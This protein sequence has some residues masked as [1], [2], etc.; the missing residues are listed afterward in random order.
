MILS[1]H[2]FFF[3]P[4]MT[5]VSSNILSILVMAE[6]VVGNFANVFIALVN[7][8]DWAKNQKISTADAILTALAVSRIGLLWVILLNWCSTVFNPAL[9]PSEMRIIV[10]NTWTV[11]NHFSLWLTA[12]LSIFYLLKIANFSNLTFLYLKK[13]IKSVV[14]ETMLVNFVFLVCYLVVLNI[15]QSIQR[16][17][18][19]GNATWKIK[20][21][22]IVQLS[23]MTVLTLVNLIPFTVSLICFLLLT[24]SLCKHLRNMQLHGLGSRDPSTQVHVKA[25][26][27]V[28]SFLLL[29]AMYFLA[30][31]ISFWSSGK[32]MSKLSH[33]FC[34]AIGIIY[35]ANHSFVLIWGNKKL[36]QNFRSLLW[37]VRHWVRGQIS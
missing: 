11:T 35:P 30:L 29:S 31:I 34:Q 23:S 20:L 28:L 26:Q 9:H 16:E 36:K 14:V 6:F 1:M 22:D 37:Q 7:C 12:S 4:D 8:I 21:R 17:E 13:R 27:T 5:S 15:G 32:S 3:I 33:M 18:L 24:C 2:F 19:E 10:S 25:V